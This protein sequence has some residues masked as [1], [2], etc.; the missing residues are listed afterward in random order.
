MHHSLT[1]GINFVD[2]KDRRSIA[3]WE[4]ALEQL[5]QLDLIVAG[6]YKDEFFEVTA[7]GY[8]LADIIAQSHRI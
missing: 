4:A 1:N 7:A 3:R 6:G 8:E 2:T 5:Q